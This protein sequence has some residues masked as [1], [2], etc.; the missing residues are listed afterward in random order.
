MATNR[1]SKYEVFIGTW[2]T[3]GRVFA[4][5]APATVIELRLERAA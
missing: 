5:R 1:M 3:T 4:T 2:N